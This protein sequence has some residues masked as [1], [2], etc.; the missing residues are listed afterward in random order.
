[1]TRSRSRWYCVRH[2]GGT[3]SYL[4]PRVSPLNCAYGA[5]V[6]RSICSSSSRVRGMVE[7]R[8]AKIGAAETESVGQQ[9]LHRNAAQ[10]EQTPDGVFDQVVRAGR[11]GRNA[12][13]DFAGRQPVAGFHFRSEVLVVVTDEFV[14]F[15]FRGVFDEVR[16]QFGFAHFGEVRSVG[17]IVTADD[18]EQ[19]EGFGEQLLERVLPV[20]RGATNRVEE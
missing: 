8:K 4:R 17:R 16:R 5:R 3:S 14:R 15:H 6:C 11:A 1:M 10:L 12:D 13:G 20:L 18:D 19:V 2:S 7:K 9:L